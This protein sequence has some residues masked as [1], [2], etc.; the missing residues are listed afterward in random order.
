MLFQKSKMSHTPHTFLWCPCIFGIISTIFGFEFSR[1]DVM[2]LNESDILL[3]GA[4]PS[5]SPW[6]INGI[7]G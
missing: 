5:H 4:K 1:S 7:Y 2:T 6:N 3:P